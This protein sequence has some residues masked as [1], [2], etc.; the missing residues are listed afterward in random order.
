MLKRRNQRQR[1]LCHVAVHDGRETGRDIRS[2]QQIQ[3]EYQEEGPLN[4][5]KH[6]QFEHACQ[7]PEAKTNGGENLHH[8]WTARSTSESPNY[9]SHSV[10]PT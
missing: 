10:R 9:Q 2:L 5:T 6:V 7:V 8:I 3:N 4:S 1:I